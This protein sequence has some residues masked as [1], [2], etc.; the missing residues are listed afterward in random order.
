MTPNIRRRALKQ[1][2]ALARDREL[3][4][5]D[6]MRWTPPQMAFLRERAQFAILTLGQQLGGV[7]APG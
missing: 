1:A 2:Q 3:H 6:Y 5:L 7:R 4:P